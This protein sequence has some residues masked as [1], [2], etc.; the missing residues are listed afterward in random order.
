VADIIDITEHMNTVTAAEQ[1]REHFLYGEGC[2][3]KG[4]LETSLLD[5]ELFAELL[6]LNAALARTKPRNS[7]EVRLLTQF[8]DTLIQQI[9]DVAEHRYE[10]DPRWG[11]TLL[12]DHAAARRSIEAFIRAA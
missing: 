5:D 11:L 8:A 2:V 4:R 12:S 7:A 1:R 10:D 3:V 6:R 9:I